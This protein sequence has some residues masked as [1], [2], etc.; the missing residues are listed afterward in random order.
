MYKQQ[1]K[2][3][4]VSFAATRGTADESTCDVATNEN[5][6]VPLN[7]GSIEDGGGF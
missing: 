4:R 6:L 7:S 1:I 3:R 2:R 5:I